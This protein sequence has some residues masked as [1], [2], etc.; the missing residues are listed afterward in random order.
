MGLGDIVQTVERREKTLTV[1]NPHPD[2]PVVDLLASY[3]ADRAVEIRADATATGRPTD[4]AVLEQAGSVIAVVSLEKLR[5]VVEQASTYAT[6][7][8]VDYGPYLELLN[9]LEEATFTSSSRAQMLATTREI[10][11]RAFRVGSGRLHAGFQDAVNLREERERYAGLAERGLDVSAHIAAT[12]APPS[13]PGV[14]VDVVD[15]P[16]VADFWAVAFDGGEA[17]HQQCALVAEERAPGRYYGFWTYDPE[18]VERTFGC[19]A[20][21]ERRAT[22]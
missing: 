13:I 9:H 8:D 16:D 15:D 10:E 3:F 21:L 12:D 4:V 20:E 11:D 22:H 6:G 19:L 1:L 2:D 5:R 14:S 7:L 17:D 18:I